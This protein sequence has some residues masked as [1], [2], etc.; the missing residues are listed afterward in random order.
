MAL[1]PRQ[2]APEAIL[3]RAWCA[4]KARQMGIKRITPMVDRA[5]RPAYTAL[6]LR[7]PPRKAA[8]ACHKLLRKSYDPA[9]RGLKNVSTRA[10]PRS[11]EVTA[12]LADQQSQFQH[13]RIFDTVANGRGDDPG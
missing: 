9:P 6:G 5:A 3:G 12:I 13:I 8:E 4:R 10:T 11:W 1:A 2:R 7:A